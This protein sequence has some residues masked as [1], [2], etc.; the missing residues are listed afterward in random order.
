MN[1][2]VSIPAIHCEGCAMLIKDVSSEF[3]AIARTDVDVA[4]KRVTLEHDDSF[5][6]AAWTAEIQS[7]NPSYVVHPAA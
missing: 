2:T 7:A 4:T 5:D 3:P 6:L 1:T